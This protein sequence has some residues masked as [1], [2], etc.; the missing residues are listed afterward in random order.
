MDK[1]KKRL[2]RTDDDEDYLDSTRCKYLKKWNKKRLN[3]ILRIMK[4]GN[5]VLK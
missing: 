1:K 2:R 5:R 3:K 4:L